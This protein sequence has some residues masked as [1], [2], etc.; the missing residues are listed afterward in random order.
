MLS[1]RLHGLYAWASPPSAL[2]SGF[3]TF[4]CEVKLGVQL[5]VTEGALSFL[6]ELHPSL[7]RNCLLTRRCVKL[8]TATAGELSEW[9]CGRR[10]ESAAL[11]TEEQVEQISNRKSEF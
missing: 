8:L 10:N 11:G 2:T 7:R 4:P 5:G 6:N 3:C 1:E 9:G